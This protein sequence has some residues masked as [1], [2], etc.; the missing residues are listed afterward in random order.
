MKIVQWGAAGAIFGLL[1]VGSPR[2]ASAQLSSDD[3]CKAT[4][5]WT[6]GLQVD[7]TH[8]GTVTVPRS[9]VVQWVGSVTAAPGPYHGSVW[10][11]LPPPF[12]KVQLHSWSGNSATTSNAGQEKYDI[13]KL[14]PGGA[15]FTVSGEHIDA[16]GT[17]AGSVDLS[18]SGGALGSP[19]TWVALGG[20]AVSG[21]SLAA[22]LRPL[23]RVVTKGVV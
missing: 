9:D 1:L 19:V 22:L 20:T 12:G 8:T 6:N 7:A 18:I 16:N 14:V 10:I 3:G 15:V 11:E 4:A 21:L 5:T 17:C 23:F 13:P 2:V